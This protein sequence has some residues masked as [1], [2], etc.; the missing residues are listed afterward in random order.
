MSIKPRG[1]KEGRVE[2]AQKF[3]DFYGVTP[4]DPLLSSQIAAARPSVKQA[5]M[6][7]VE[8]LKGSLLFGASTVISAISDKDLYEGVKKKLTEDE[9]SKIRFI[10]FE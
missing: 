7:H 9:I 4:V 3:S 6:R 2:R 8:Q 10:N 1:Q 5:V